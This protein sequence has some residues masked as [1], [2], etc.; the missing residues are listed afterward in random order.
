MLQKMEDWVIFC[1]Y[2]RRR[3]SKK[4]QGNKTRRN[5]D[6]VL[7]GKCDN[8]LVYNI[9]ESTDSGPPLPSPSCSS[10]ISE[11]VS[12]NHAST[13]QEETCSNSNT[14]PVSSYW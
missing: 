3:R 2:Q 1:I 11:H 7:A 13:D 6:D 4:H 9:H 10:G 12:L 14:I 5:E 8:F